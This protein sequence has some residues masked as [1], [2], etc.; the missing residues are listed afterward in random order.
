VQVRGIIRA[1]AVGKADNHDR[2]HQ[3]LGMATPASLSR[4]ATA[5]TT[6]SVPAR[7]TLR[8]DGRLITTPFNRA[9]T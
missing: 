1:S 3:S 8:L 2:P 6:A 9:V 7:V 4:L 5:P